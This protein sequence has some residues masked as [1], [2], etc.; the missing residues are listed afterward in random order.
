[1]ASSKLKAPGKVA[2]TTNVKSSNQLRKSKEAERA[3]N[4]A[5]EAGLNVADTA[6]P[7][8]ATSE[9]WIKARQRRYMPLSQLICLS[10][11]WRPA[12]ERARSD[13]PEQSKADFNSRALTLKNSLTRKKTPNRLQY[14]TVEPHDVAASRKNKLLYHIDVVNFVA[15]TQAREINIEP[16]LSKTGVTPY[17]SIAALANAIRATPERVKKGAEKNI[18]SGYSQILLGLLIKHYQYIPYAL[19]SSGHHSDD[20]NLRTVREKVRTSLQ[21]LSIEVSDY[22]INRRITDSWATLK[23]TGKEVQLPELIRQF[24]KERSDV[25]WPGLIQYL[26]PKKNVEK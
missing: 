11:G 4:L 17:P 16:A 6:I 5:P 2:K 12:T 24:F 20:G 3:V 25:T 13:W 9:D 10:F 23:N 18:D 22:V 21:E 7:E 26:R 15:F 14:E 8:K 1:M 19:S